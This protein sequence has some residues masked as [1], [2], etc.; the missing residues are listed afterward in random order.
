M[1]YQPLNLARWILWG[2]TAVLM[3]VLPLIFT[4]GFAI[5]LMS[6]MGVAIIFT[7][8]YNML[9]GQSGMLSFG[10]AVY[11]GLGAYI[12][13]HTLNMASKGQL[14]M[15]V[16]LLPLVGGL[17]GA[18]FGVLFGYVTTK[19]AGTTFAMITLGIGELVFSCSLMF[20]DFFG[21]EGGISANRVFG[22]PFLGL[23][24]GPAVQVYYLI[25]LWCLASMALMYA[26]SHTPLGRMA[27]AVRDNPERAEFVGYDTQKV[28]WLTLII[29]AFFAGIAGALG[30]IN[31]EI[32]TA[33]NVSA[34]RSGGV[35]L[36]AFI[37]GVGFFFGPIIGA[38]VFVYFVVALSDHT[39]AWQLYLGLF[40]ILTV[41]FAP[42]GIA[43]LI[44]M[45]LPV[46]ARKRFKELVPHYLATGASGLLVLAAIVLTVEMTYKVS[47]DSANGTAMSLFGVEFDASNALPWAIAGGLWLVGGG[48]FNATR[49]RLARVW[50]EIQAE[51]AGARA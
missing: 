25:A 16:S 49:R 14:W 6:Q 32:V 36:A 12:A 44:M 13:V 37:G 48:L 26:W 40:F 33:E 27:N 4:Q 46:I 45:Q 29:S 19:R 23:T 34:V 20:P 18:F 3:A 11:S 50:G 17:A 8:S 43:S 5:T 38:C 7:L 10:H 1:R 24:F 41:M 47:V 42:G 28:R 35:L 22:K 21:G 30:C 15:P 2:A 31:F 39:K 51:I 9:L